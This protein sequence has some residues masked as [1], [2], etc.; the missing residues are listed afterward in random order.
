MKRISGY[1]AIGARAHAVV[2]E[3]VAGEGVVRLEV[4]RESRQRCA[5]DVSFV[6]SETNA[7]ELVRAIQGRADEAKRLAY[8]KA[9]RGTTPELDH[10][11]ESVAKAIGGG[12]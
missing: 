8:V 4:R 10:A 12:P 11:V 6:L 2:F 9:K 1:S 7:R 5:G 3:A